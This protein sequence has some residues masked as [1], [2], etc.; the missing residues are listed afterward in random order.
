MSRLSPD[1]VE[2][3]RGAVDMVD[4]VGGRTQL[5]REGARFSARCPFHEERTASF[6]LDPVAKL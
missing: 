4:L 6:S 3:V 2:A 1:S 5:K